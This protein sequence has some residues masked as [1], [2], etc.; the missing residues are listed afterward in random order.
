MFCSRPRG[1]AGGSLPERP[2]SLRVRASRVRQSI[3]MAH[4]R[5]CAAL[6]AACREQD[7][8]VREKARVGCWSTPEATDTDA[9]SHAAW[10]LLGIARS[11]LL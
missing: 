11:S 8:E 4:G 6:R 3:E 2:H 7:I 5:T 9:A 1:P 10:R